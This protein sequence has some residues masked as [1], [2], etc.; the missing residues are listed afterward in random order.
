[1]NKKTQ[2]HILRLTLTAIIIGLNL[3]GVIVTSAKGSD[4]QFSSNQKAVLDPKAQVLSS[5]I[6][7]IDFLDDMLTKQE[8]EQ[9]VVLELTLPAHTIDTHEI[10]GGSCQT[11]QLEG[12]SNSSEPGWPQLPYKGTSIAL[13]DNAQAVLNILDEETAVLDGNFEICPAS[14][15][16]VE[17]MPDGEIAYSGEEAVR[18]Q[19]AYLLNSFYPAVSVEL[20]E[21][22]SIRGQLVSQLQFHPYQYNPTT[23]QVRVVNRIKVQIDFGQ[24]IGDG[25][26]AEIFSDE[27]IIDSVLPATQSNV[28]LPIL[29]S[30][31]SSSSSSQQIK[32]WVDV[33]GLYQV[34]YE[35]LSAAGAVFSGVDPNTFQIQTQGSEIA[36]EVTGAGDGSFDPGDQVIFYG[37]PVDTRYTGSN[38]YW[39]SWGESSGTRM[40]SESVSTKTGN[41]SE[42]FL[43]NKR[44]E[45]NTIYQSTIYDTRGDHWFWAF[46]TASTAPVNWTYVFQVNEPDITTSDNAVLSGSIK[47]QYATPKHHTKIY[48][49][50]HF[51]GE[52]YYN[53]GTQFDFSFPFPNNYLLQGDNTLRVEIPVDGGITRDSILI[54]WFELDY[55]HTFRAEQDQLKFKS[56]VSGTYEY[57]VDNFSVDQI[58]LY[59]ITNPAEPSRMVDFTLTP[60]GSGYAVNFTAS[61]DSQHEYLA[62]NPS[63]S[64][65]PARI[66]VETPSN[67]K[68]AANG[69]DYLLISHA[70]FLSEMQQLANWRSNQGLR[71]AI[72][73]VQD[74]YDEFNNGVLDPT[75]I[76]DFIAFAYQSWQPPAP[77]YVLLAGDG[78]NDPRNYKGTNEPIYIPAYILPVDN[79]LYETA[80][81]NRYVTVSGTDN[82]PDLMIGRLPIK[83]SAEAAAYI[84]KLINYE[85]APYSVEWNENVLFVSDNPDSGGDFISYSEEI[86][87][88]Y[89][90]DGYN[91]RKVYLGNTHPTA[92]AARAAIVENINQGNLIVNYTGHGFQTAW[93]SENLLTTAAV[94]SLTNT[95][96]PAFFAMM[97]CLTG[98]F[99][100]PSTPTTDKSSLAEVLTKANN[101]GA[102]VSWASSGMGL[103]AGQ[104]LLNKGLYQA[105]LY[106]GENRVGEAVMQAKLYLVSNSQSY[107][108]L[109]DLFTLFGDPATNLNVVPSDL[110]VQLSVSPN[111]GVQNGMPITYTLTYRN[112]GLAEASNI[113]IDHPLP[114]KLA[115][116][117]VTFS[118][119]SG[120]QI[121]GSWLSWMLPKLSPGQTG[122]I[123]V[124]GRVDTSE[125][126]IL[127]SQA[128]IESPIFD[129]DESNNLSNSVAIHVNSPTAT[130]LI[131]AQASLQNGSVVV[132]WETAH[133]LDLLGFNLWRSTG[134]QGEKTLIVN[135]P[136]QNNGSLVG[137]QYSTID[138]DIQLGQTYYYEIEL[139]ETGTSSWVQLAPVGLSTLVYLPVI[140]R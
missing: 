74:I 77:K 6:A 113:Q 27:M 44:I 47:S 57:F 136:S 12:F 28:E 133:E 3:Q 17:I 85:Q 82:F 78:H 112:V 71:V 95:D 60:S 100:N 89:L 122:T 33:E 38:V 29:E 13:P 79:Y 36:I 80:S 42:H 97:A 111:G 35:M 107:R 108:D 137:A 10:N 69:A 66:A 9:G 116:P 99:Q 2:T 110:T 118:D 5:E 8:T 139:L 63:Q 75:A 101:K 117:I 52:G 49:N 124:T 131:S 16:V 56:E 67:L 55:W 140:T 11:F 58:S 31:S 115:D 114:E 105:I 30:S 26:S 41:S 43:A 88:Y 127:I 7:P 59:D 4:V 96:K 19:E 126:E 65:A 70:D 45:T 129:A 32:M 102:V 20:S 132:D 128:S 87:N 62:I 25:G 93:A 34:S 84:S 134:A 106:A 23:K 109:L 119:P 68:S 48:L 1:M 94:N 61:T 39:L 72:V 120:Y 40:S 50:E 22:D 18:D 104:S 24:P 46:I 51:I 138:S 83:T 135:L 53:T 14:R 92:T 81:D 123:Q 15:P 98:F 121:E 21:A 90:P 73:D 91:S 130:T 86:A 54:N 64:M 103:A 125:S 76:R 37:E